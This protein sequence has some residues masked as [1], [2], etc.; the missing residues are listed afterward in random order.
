MKYA[1]VLLALLSLALV[2]QNPTD[3]VLPNGKTW[4]EELIAHNH[5]ENVKDAKKLAE[6]TAQIAAELD[7]GDKYVFSLKTLRNLE[8]AEKLAKNIRERMSTN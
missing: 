6:L 2:A 1:V 3:V 8:E 7:A 5:K 4:K